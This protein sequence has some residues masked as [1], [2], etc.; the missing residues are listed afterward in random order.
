MRTDVSAALQAELRKD[1]F[2]PYIKITVGYNGDDL[3]IP[4]D[5]FLEFHLHPYGRLG[6][7]ELDFKINTSDGDYLWLLSALGCRIDDVQI[8]A[9]VGG[10]IEH[11]HLE[12]FLITGV[13]ASGPSVPQFVTVTAINV[14]R[15]LEQNLN[16]ILPHVGQSIQAI[17]GGDLLSNAA[18]IPAFDT[19]TFWTY[20]LGTFSTQIGNSLKFYI[21]QLIGEGQSYWRALGRYSPTSAPELQL[22]GIDLSPAIDGQI[23][24]ASTPRIHS[25]AR[26]RRRL[27]S[28]VTVQGAGGLARRVQSTVLEDV[29]LEQFPFFESDHFL[30]PQFSTAAVLEARAKTEIIVNAGLADT[31]LIK[32]DP[33]LRLQLWDVIQV[34]GLSTSAAD[35]P[36]TTALRVA[37]IWLDYQPSQFTFK[38][39]AWRCYDDLGYVTTTPDPVSALVTLASGADNKARTYSGLS[40]DGNSLTINPVTAA[41]PLILGTNALGQLVTDLNAD[42]VDGIHAAGFETAGSIATHTALTTGVHGL[43]IAAGKT[44]TV[45]DNLTVG[46]LTAGRVL[47][48]SAT[49]TIGNDSALIWDNVNKWLGIGKNPT[50]PLDIS[51]AAVDGGIGYAFRLT[52]PY[53]TKKVGNAV[54]FYLGTYNTNL[55]GMIAESAAADE[56]ASKLHF[57]AS[58]SLDLAQVG[59]TLFGMNVGVGTLVPD[60]I[61]HVFGAESAAG[62]YTT[63]GLFRLG[64]ANVEL[65]SGIK[66]D[67]GNR[68]VW[69]QSRHPSYDI[70]YD[71]ALNPLGGNTGFGTTTPVTLIHGAISATTAGIVNM[72]TLERTGASANG[73]GQAI[74]FN[75][76]SSTTLA[77]PIGLISARWLDKTHASSTTQMDFTVYSGVATARL[78]LSL[79][80]STT[81]AMI[82]FLGATPITRPAALTA[83][84][85][86]AVNS[87][88]ATTDGVINNIRTR[89][90]EL[91]DKLGHTAGLGLIT[92]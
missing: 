74:L 71:L 44:L 69:L 54:A 67:T 17:L 19:S 16:S 60:A 51:S 79:A 90:G 34:T 8:G 12:R 6:R 59:L 13:K 78:A 82:G 40:F 83:A 66:T 62:V 86:S 72:L 42:T 1:A 22:I 81:A 29:S 33:D 76:K 32:C 10:V 50:A 84:D 48:A 3:D 49:G 37:E 75:G 15:N 63:K 39:L 31:F 36:D 11:V 18:I 21:N 61:L 45:T 65:A 70:K 46:T 80:S 87:S 23:G 20:T 35:L 88:D 53:T 25:I 73:D 43:A 7:A 28:T 85:A 24:T 91:E 56:T 4:L 30:L 9:V 52:N 68:Y 2:V 77:Q 57:V 38:F 27:P 58:S 92:H 64:S 47:F 55:G 26:T 41:P 14:A 89:L 5:R